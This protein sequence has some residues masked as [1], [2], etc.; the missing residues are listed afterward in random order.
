[1]RFYYAPMEGLTGH[2]CRRVHHE[3]FPGVDRYYTPFVTATHTRS[4]KQKEKHDVAP[5]NNAVLI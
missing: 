5:E 4:F 1:M 3:F 2:V